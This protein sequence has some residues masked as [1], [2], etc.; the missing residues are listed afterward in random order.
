MSFIRCDRGPT[1]ADHH[2]LGDGPGPG[3]PLRPF[4]VSGL[5]TSTRWPP[6]ANTSAAQGH[7]RSWGI[8]RHIQGSQIFDYSRDPEGYL[9]EHFTDGDLF[10]NTLDP[11]LGALH[12][13]RVGPMG[14]LPV[15]EGFPRNR[16]EIGLV[17]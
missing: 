11:G 17:V 1:P 2:T 3:Q 15:T 8:G 9:F 16:T 7:R 14:A 12:R 4:G 5:A 6:A 13:I 10:D